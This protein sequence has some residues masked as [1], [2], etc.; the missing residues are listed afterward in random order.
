MS[1]VYDMTWSP[2]HRWLLC[3]CEAPDQGVTTAGE[4]V[5]CL[6]VQTGEAAQICLK[7]HVGVGWLPQVLCPCSTP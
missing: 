2:C 4:R 3:I 7:G 5:R 6:D 1:S